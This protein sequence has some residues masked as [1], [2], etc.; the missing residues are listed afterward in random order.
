MYAGAVKEVVDMRDKYVDGA[1]NGG[2]IE[3]LLNVYVPS[4]V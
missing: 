3:T 4:N 2:N 1:L